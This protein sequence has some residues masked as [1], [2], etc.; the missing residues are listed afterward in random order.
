MEE[1]HKCRPRCWDLPISYTHGDL[2]VNHVLSSSI[3]EGKGSSFQR[4]CMFLKTKQKSANQPLEAWMS[5][6]VVQGRFLFIVTYWVL[7]KSTETR[8]CDRCEEDFPFP[9]RM[10][11]ALLFIRLLFLSDLRKYFTGLSAVDPLLTP[12]MSKGAL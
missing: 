3:A 2:S 5:Y 10:I 4:Q 9:Q 11:V 6:A 8:T 7:F 1:Q 12:M